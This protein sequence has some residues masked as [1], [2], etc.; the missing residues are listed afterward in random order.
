MG[1]PQIVAKF[2][3]RTKAEE[4]FRIAGMS[5]PLLID[6]A[7]REA[8]VCTEEDS[9]GGTGTSARPKQSRWQTVEDCSTCENHI[10]LW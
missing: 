1:A 6:R 8:V 5:S 7:S 3:G 4:G 9:L 10:L 2:L